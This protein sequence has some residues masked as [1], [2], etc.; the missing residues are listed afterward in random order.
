VCG[1]YCLFFGVADGF[2]GKAL[3]NLLVLVMYSLTFDL[4]NFEFSCYLINK[5]RVF[6]W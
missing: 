3:S 4:K 2:V 6:V 5:R 1:V